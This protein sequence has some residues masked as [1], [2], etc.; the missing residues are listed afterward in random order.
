MTPAPQLPDVRQHLAESLCTQWRRYRKQLKRCQRQFSEAAVHKSRVET[1]RLLATVEL[2]CAFFPERD[3]KKARRALKDHLDSFDQL[4]DTQVQLV[5]VEHLVRKNPAARKFCAWLRKREERFICES[6]KAVR[7]IRTRRLG[8]RIAGFQSELEA[9]RKHTKPERAFSMAQGAIRLAFARVAQLCRQ[10]SADDTETIHRTRIAFKRFRYMVDALS[11]LLPAV[12]DQHRQAM[13][14]Y[15][16]MMGDI[17]DIEVLLATLDKFIKHGNHDVDTQRLR[18]EF[19]R[20]REQLIRVYLNAAGKL[21][22]FWPLQPASG[23]ITSNRK[24]KS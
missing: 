1:R 23:T 3:L 21:Q 24:G 4:R 22:Q 19:T 13:R 17:Q 15:Q 16:S 20:R 8:K 12:T 6:R 11:A 2:L 10:V 14:G 18:T 5:Y 9:L 7:K